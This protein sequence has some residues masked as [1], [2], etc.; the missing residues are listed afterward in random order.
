MTRVIVSPLRLFRRLGALLW[1][2]ALA[3]CAT[4][5]LATDDAIPRSDLA[6]EEPSRLERLADAAWPFP[7]PK[8]YEI[9]FAFAP[10]DPPAA[11]VETL[12]G[13]SRAVVEQREEAPA[14]VALRRRARGDADRLTRA[15]KSEGYLTATAAAMVA[16]P[17]GE[18]EIPLV[19]FEIETGER[20]TLAA[21][22]IVETA[23][24]GATPPAPGQPPETGGPARS[25]DI[26]AAEEARLTALRND[27]YPYAELAGRAARADLKARTL[28]VTS[29]IDTGPGV[30]FGPVRVRGAERTETSFVEGYFEG[31]D[32]APASRAALARIERRLAETRLFRGAQANLPEAPPAGD[33]PVPVDVSLVEAP[34]RSIGFGLRYNTAD[35][36][37][38]RVFWEHRNLSGRAERLR[39]ESTAAVELQDLSAT[40]RIPRFLRADQ[41]FVAS[42]S[43]ARQDNDAFERIGALASTGVERRL[44]ERW[45]VGAGL[46]GDVSE[47]NEGDGAETSYLVG[48]P[49]GA[50]YDSADDP[51]DP[52]TGERLALEMTPWVGAQAGRGTGFVALSAAG[53]IYR[54]LIRSGR[55]VWATRARAAT[56][57]GASLRDVPA[58]RRL[59]AGGGGSVRGFA[60]RLLGPLDSDGDPSGGLT[61]LDAGAEL[62]WRVTETIGLAPF[63][64]AGTVAEQ[65]VDVIVR[66]VE[67]GAGLG[68]RY[69]S[70]V[71]PLRLDVA[72]PL[73]PRRID[74][75]VQLYVGIGQAF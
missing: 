31:L 69:K 23:P 42:G 3:G 73:N 26:L 67:F 40:G 9:E 22:E 10:E 16:P 12:R 44:T 47:I 46:S 63:I 49:L 45:T 52:T 30:V 13:A 41:T 66:D 27:G 19:R 39:I 54:P 18:R 61:A 38:A 58:N 8:A 50:Q 71:G 1:P 28:R 33:G 5:G 53:S 35:G 11:V 70:P 64:E 21:F 56:V 75:P 6:A 34:P 59:F 57:A 62:R 68:F 24:E 43:A 17:E 15:M 14:E 29:R 7:K 55:V 37:G 32:G 20:F 74:D 51:L 48:T 2:L 60:A 65:P 36:P 4:L 25:A 72:A